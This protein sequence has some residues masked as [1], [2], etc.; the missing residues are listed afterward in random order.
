MMQSQTRNSM[1]QNQMAFSAVVLENPEVQDLFLKGAGSSDTSMYQEGE[2]GRLSFL[3]NAQLRMW[4][5]EWY[6]YNQGLFEPNEF[7]PRMELWKGEMQSGR[8]RVVW[9]QFREAYSVE[10]RALIDEMVDGG[11]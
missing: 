8:H 5:N 3:L 4:E 9:D 6:Q 2:I 7:E 10:F 1:T 11:R